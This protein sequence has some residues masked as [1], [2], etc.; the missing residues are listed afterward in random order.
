MKMKTIYIQPETQTIVLNIK[1]RILDM[2]DIHRASVEAF[3][4]GANENNM[5]E[6]ESDEPFWDLWDNGNDKKEE[7]E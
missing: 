1:D 7:D 3:E 6:P 4:Q 2:G 5:F